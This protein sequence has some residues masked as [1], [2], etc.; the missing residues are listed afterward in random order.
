MLPLQGVLAGDPFS[1]RVFRNGCRRVVN[2]WEGQIEDGTKYYLRA[3]APDGT[4]ADCS[5]CVYADD[6]AKL[7]FLGKHANAKTLRLVPPQG[8]PAET[9]GER[10]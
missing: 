3:R 9:Q 1:V 2:E 10:F 4:R 7:I 6:I 8:A 5:K